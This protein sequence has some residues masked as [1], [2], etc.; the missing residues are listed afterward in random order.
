MKTIKLVAIFAV[1]LFVTETAIAANHYVRS[2]ARGANNGGDW[3]NAY[4]SLPSNLIRGD[5]YY[6]ADGTYVSY[7][8]N[9]A[10]SGTQVITIKKA[11]ASDH[12]TQ[13]G[14]QSTF[15]DGEAVFQSATTVWQFNTPYYVVDGQ[16]GSGKNP[17]GYGFRVYS[18]ASRSSAS[19]FYMGIIEGNNITM[20]HVEWDWNNGTGA[21]SSG[22]P[23]MLGGF[24]SYGTIE[25]SYF[26]HAPSYAFDFGGYPG[27]TQYTN[28]LIRDN[29]FYMIGGGGGTNAHWELFW[30]MNFDNS[31]ISRNTFENVFG[32]VEGQT[33]WIM[34]GK[35]DNLKIHGNL[36]FCSN[37]SF[38]S[39]GGNGVIATWSNDVYVNHGIYIYNNTF[40]KLSGGYGPKIYFS[41]NSADDTNIEVKNNL[42]FN[43][44][45]GWQGV[46]AHSNEACGG[47]QGCAGTSQQTGLNTS[48]FANY[49]GNNFSLASPTS[50]G[51][52]LGSQF[53]IDMNSLVRGADGS[54]DRGAYEFSVEAPSFLSPSNLRIAP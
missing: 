13:T 39:I 2:G 16:K 10:A 45:F 46:D 50:T 22:A 5:V 12:G 41:H 42:Y 6:I 47:G 24:A 43:S 23:R 37:S 4:T 19:S 26:H 49:S 34:V 7:N 11:I 9:D 48:I 33:G 25:S 15:G 38:C 17:G 28:W 40:A 31:E 52:N 3:T 21:T 18:S 32:D 44:R 20:R 27:N 36:F 35:T 14:W 29:Y 51:I 54:W 8:F 1:F 53:S 30:W